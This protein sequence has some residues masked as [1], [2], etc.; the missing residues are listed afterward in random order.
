MVNNT[1]DFQVAHPEIIKQ[2]AVKDMLFVYFQCP[3]V[4]KQV[5]L[6]VHYN[7]IIFTIRGTKTFH[8]REKSW[9]LSEHDCVFFRKAAYTQER[10]DLVG[11]EVLA[12]YFTDEFVRK[13]FMDHR[14]HLPLKNLPPPPVD[15]L[16]NI[17]VNETAIAFFYSM[18]PYFTQKF[19]PA[20]SLVE[21]KFK[22]LLF[23]VLSNPANQDLLAY[24]NSME[25]DHRTSIREIMEGNYTYNL[26]IDQFARMAGRSVSSFK[27]EFQHYYKVSPGRWLTNKRLEY[28]K[29]L[30]E[31]SQKNVSEIVDASGFESKA[32]FSRAF[33]EKYELSPLHYRRK[34]SSSFSE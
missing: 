20:E 11:W 13:L 12:F 15:R 7:M 21:L 26:S 9:T 23:N 16:I 18:I 30:L 3:Q 10:D 8:H 25:D 17:D 34:I 5:N 14:Q 28:A 33:K 31:T 6:Y 22:E 29:H 24:V 19:P 27:R 4:E 1:Y 32:H 2:F